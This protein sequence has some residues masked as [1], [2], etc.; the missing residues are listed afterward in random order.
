VVRF[1]APTWVTKILLLHILLLVILVHTCSEVTEGAL[2]VWRT[3]PERIRQDPS[4]ASFRQEHERLHGG[5]FGLGILI[6]PP[7]S[8]NFPFF[9]PGCCYL[10]IAVIIAE[11]FIAI[12]VGVA[13]DIG[14]CPVF[15]LFCL[16]CI[17]KT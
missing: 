17:P 15:F 16:I 6:L 14:I 3:L 10:F 9:M 11:F 2:Q 7:G 1:I 13:I 8:H 5:K 4:L 12:C